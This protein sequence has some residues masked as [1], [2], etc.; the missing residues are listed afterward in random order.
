MKY[1]IIL[2]PRGNVA[3]GGLDVI[4]R[5]DKYAQTLENKS[6]DSPMTLKIYSATN[7]FYKPIAHNKLSNNLVLISKPRMSPLLFSLRAIIQIKREKITPSLLVAGDPWES[8][9]SAFLVNLFLRK[10]IPVQVQIHADI[11][12]P[13]WR[14]LN[15]KN[16]LKYAVAKFSLKF[17]TRI[18]LVA[19]SQAIGLERY[20]GV[21][22]EKIDIAPVP[23]NIISPVVGLNKQAVPPFQ[24]GLV[25][26][27]HKDRGLETFLVLVKKIN[28]V[29][30]DFQIN[31]I[32]DGPEKE[33]FISQLLENFSADR[34]HMHGLLV[35]E[36]MLNIWEE[37]DV[38]VSCAPV[39]S[40]GRALRESIFN[41][42]PVWATMSEGTKSL[43]SEI[44][45]EDVTI[46]EVSKNANDLML[47]L[48][49]IVHRE[50]PT[51]TRLKILEKQNSSMDLL[52]ETWIKTMHHKKI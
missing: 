25:G 26:R 9:L 10:R 17:A 18:R 15:W 22:S 2:D 48:K 13:K 8:A 38:L 21:P 39:E 37:L 29:Y 35:G 41:G 23:L 4:N 49:S 46:L 52:V 7:S 33:W 20:F 47:D 45:E 3:M 11:T 19:M 5:H 12:D 1:V 32:G 43:I 27:V 51:S 6:A 42:V 28:S 24:V 36:K 44:G 40:Y 30:S 16:N 31:I 50:I 34:I 14:K